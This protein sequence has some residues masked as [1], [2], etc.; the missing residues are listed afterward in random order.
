LA[1]YLPQYHRDPANDRWWGPGYTDWRRVLAARPR[2][3]GH[4]QPRRPGELG[5]YDL[6]D[7]PTLPAQA[8]LA[9]EHRVDGFI[10]YHYWSAGQRLLHAPIEALLR[11]RSVRLPFAVCWA[12][13]SWTDV[14]GPTYGSDPARWTGTRRLFEQH[15]SPADDIEHFRHLARYIGDDRY[16]RLDG[17]PLLLIWRT[18]DLPNPQ[19]TSHTGRAESHRHGLGELYL[20]GLERPG[21]PPDPTMLDAD[22]CYEPSRARRHATGLR[23]HTRTAAGD[24]LYDYP[25]QAQHALRYLQ[26]TAPPSHPCVFPGWDNSP[27]RHTG[28]TIYTRADP[29]AYGQ[30]LAGACRFALHDPA[31]PPVVFVNAWNEWAEGCYLEPDRHYGRSYLEEHRRVMTAY[32]GRPLYRPPTPAESGRPAGC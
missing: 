25:T 27:R 13:E 30:W 3:P 32:S 2:F 9:A 1:F 7:P 4:R 17:R 29:A 6:L 5:A 10:Y 23:P 19:A 24:H 16:I 14:W 15:Y 18:A 21:H 8:E 12:N 28:A 20:C 31:T 11:R 22:V 26:Q